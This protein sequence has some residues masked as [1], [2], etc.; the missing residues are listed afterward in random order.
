MKIIEIK[1]LDN[2]AHRNQE[3]AIST[4][5]EGWAVIP[6]GMELPNFPFGEVKARK[7]KGVK[8]VTS[9]IPGEIPEEEEE[10]I[11]ETEKLKAEIEQLRAELE[12]ITNLVGGGA[13]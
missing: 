13:K 6:D 5:P 8:T 2:G 9:W 12:R 7:K 10:P 4:I 3:G 11:S 1:A